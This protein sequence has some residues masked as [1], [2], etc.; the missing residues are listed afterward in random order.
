MKALSRRMWRYEA[1]VVPAS[2]RSPVAAS[3]LGRTATSLGAGGGVGSF[4]AFFVALL[5]M[6]SRRKVAMVTRATRAPTPTQMARLVRMK[7]SSSTSRLFRSATVQYRVV[8]SRLMSPKMSTAL[9]S[10]S[11]SRLWVQFPAMLQAASSPMPLV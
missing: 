5:V 6:T 4:F 2:W 3:K 11:L 8:R 10:Q 1:H 9:E 7:P